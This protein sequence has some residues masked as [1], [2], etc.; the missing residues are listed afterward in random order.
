MPLG[1]YGKYRRRVRDVG[2]SMISPFLF[3][4]PFHPNTPVYSF[5]AW[6]GGWLDMYFLILSLLFLS[7]PILLVLPHCLSPLLLLAD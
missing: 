1:E 2:L 3:L 4:L 7:L 5:Q 6:V